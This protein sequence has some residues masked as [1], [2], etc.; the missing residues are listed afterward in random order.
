MSIMGKK[1]RKS[2][3]QAQFALKITLLYQSNTE[4]ELYENSDNL[5]SSF[6]SCESLHIK[7]TEKRVD[8]C[9]ERVL[10]LSLKPLDTLSFHPHTQKIF[11][12]VR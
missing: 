2:Q 5:V 7:C 4:R 6:Y 1:R 3:K 8:T 10:G 12:P 11:I 9:D